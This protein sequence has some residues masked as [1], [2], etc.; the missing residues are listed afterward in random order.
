MSVAGCPHAAELGVT[1]RDPAPRGG[2]ESGEFWR[3]R[4]AP[5]LLARG[6]W[7]GFLVLGTV[8]FPSWRN[9]WGL[10]SG[11]ALLLT[12]AQ[13][14]L[15]AGS[16]LLHELSHAEV[17]YRSGRTVLSVS[18][19]FWGGVTA[20]VPQSGISERPGRGAWIAAAGPAANLAVAAVARLALSAWPASASLTASVAHQL[21]WSLL[22]FNLALGLFNLLPGY[23]MD[24]GHVLDSVVTRITGRGSVGRLVAGWA[25]RLVAVAVLV[26]VILPDLL[27]ASRPDSL[28]VIWAVFIAFFLWTGASGA[29]RTAPLLRRRESLPVE[30]L[31]RPVVFL[32]AD[33]S[34][35]RVRRLLGRPSGAADPHLRDPAR[36]TI[37]FINAASCVVDPVALA[38]VSEADVVQATAS[39]VMVPVS[40]AVVEGD[41][42]ARVSDVTA[43]VFDACLS[44]QLVLIRT[45]QGILGGVLASDVARFEA[46]SRAGQV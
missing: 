1:Q 27:S 40:V 43:A 18:L 19:T 15:L 33:D 6:W 21:L 41:S 36:D 31:L 9:S 3:Y 5:V 39:A 35:D 12:V 20:S 22:M 34:L 38:S 17:A 30:A 16:V 26:A 11:E 7:L 14:A 42:S 44:H 23:P 37:G 24:G 10:G 29:L 32:Q 13:C 4:G 2:R 25:G 45:S 8:F 46:S 28:S